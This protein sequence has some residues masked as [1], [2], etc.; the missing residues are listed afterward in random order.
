MDTVSFPQS[1]ICIIIEESEHGSVK[2]KKIIWKK[3]VN[4]MIPTP[5]LAK[6]TEVTDWLKNRRMVREKD[7]V[8]EKDGE[9]GVVTKHEEWEKE[10][11]KNKLSQQ[12]RYDYIKERA[13]QLE[14]NAKRKEQI[15]SVTKKGSVED[16][17]QVNDMIFESIKAKLS[18]LEEFNTNDDDDAQ[19]V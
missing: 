2:R 14:E 4:P 6:S 19:E 5:Q 8:G 11:S 7:G 17:D 18:I 10:L 1:L 9:H 13:Q 12:E 3:F 15:L 16:N